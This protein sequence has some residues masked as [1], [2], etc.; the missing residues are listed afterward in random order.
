MK[1]SIQRGGC[2]TYRVL[3][4]FSLFLLTACFAG[5]CA[6]QQDV[7]SIRENPTLAPTPYQKLRSAMPQMPCTRP[8]WPREA[9]KKEL[10]GTVTMKFLIDV[11]GRVLEKEV[12]KSSG[13]EILD[14]AA[15]EATARC[16][17]TVSPQ[18]GQLQ[19]EWVVNQYV[20][21]LD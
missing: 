10:T 14:S 17:L 4:V 20:W 1:K 3:Q 2:R 15:L 21:T 18:N 5:Q 19:K 12:V 7:A 9:L 6:A 11:D 16:K 13:H 8:A